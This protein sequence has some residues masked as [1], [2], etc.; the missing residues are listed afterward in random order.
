MNKQPEGKM[1]FPSYCFSEEWCKYSKISLNILGNL[2]ASDRASAILNHVWKHCI[3]QIS[4]KGEKK[5][6]IEKPSGSYCCC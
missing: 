6:S 5:K 2:Y 4:E 3:I 1:I